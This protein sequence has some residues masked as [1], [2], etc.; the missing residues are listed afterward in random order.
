MPPV[1]SE[2]LRVDC[3]V[4]WLRTCRPLGACQHVPMRRLRN[5]YKRT[6]VFRLCQS[7][8]SMTTWTCAMPRVSDLPGEGAVGKGDC[9]TKPLAQ[10][11]S[12]PGPG[13]S[14]R[15][16]VGGHKTD[17]GASLG[18][19]LDHPGCCMVQRPAVT[20]QV[21]DAHLRAEGRRRYAA[22][23]G[24]GEYPRHTH[25][26][27]I[28]ASL[29]HPGGKSV[30]SLVLRSSLCTVATRQAVCLPR[31]G[32]CHSSTWGSVTDQVPSASAVERVAPS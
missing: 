4:H 19:G 26:T 11:R 24:V 17:A 9:R 8:P 20:A 31:E 25:W 15:G 3:A 27:P 2:C 22:E 23:S 1:H 7:R 29:T 13:L 12:Q 5:P 14:L 16:R 30:V 6:A 10:A 21:R 18:V 28:T 32:H